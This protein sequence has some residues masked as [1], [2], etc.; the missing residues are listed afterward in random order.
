MISRKTVELNVYARS[1]TG[2]QWVI[3][4]FLGGRSEGRESS[5]M[6]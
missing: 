1:I 6:R 2:K 4:F 5:A 3:F